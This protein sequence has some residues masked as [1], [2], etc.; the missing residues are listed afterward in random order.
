MMRDITP[1]LSAVRFLSSVLIPLH[2]LGYILA[3]TSI[4][5]GAPAPG[6]DKDVIKLYNAHCRSCHGKD[7]RGSDLRT[8]LPKIPDF[9][10]VPWQAEH[11]E[12]DI[13]RKIVEGHEPDMPA[14]KDK[15]AKEE[16]DALV[17]FVR[18][19]AEDNK[20]KDT[21]RQAALVQDPK[22]AKL[23]R[24]SGCV[25]CHAKDGKGG[26]VKP[27]MPTIPD[28]TT[29]A[30]QKSRSNAQ[31]TASILDGKGTSMPPFRE[32]MKAEEIKNLIG[33]VRAFGTGEL[34][35]ESP[36]PLSEFEEKF[37]TLE[38]ELEALKKQH[39]ELRKKAKR[40][41]DPN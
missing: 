14:F 16:R 21:L 25:N 2:A 28:F 1:M 15:L 35:T 30:W 23:Y 6:A 19:F 11:S 36:T 33:Y 39:E 40:P 29:A 3:A 26:T 5:H 32:K 13:G 4:A 24:E 38:E 31:L 41:G 10:S 8:A 37:R 27:N 9:T 22:L 7:G 20:K 18:T 17:A 34:P 12:I